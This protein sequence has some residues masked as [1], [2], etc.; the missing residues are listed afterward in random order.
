MAVVYLHHRYSEDLDFFSDRAFSREEL[1]P[2]TQQLQMSLLLDSLEE[3]KVFDRREFFLHN[4]DS[5]RLEFVHYAHPNI[6]S[7]KQWQ[8]IQIDSLDDIAANKIMALVD[9]N[10]PKDA[11][12]MY[13]LLTKGDYSLQKLLGFVKQKFGTEISEDLV[14]S[15]AL[16]SARELDGLKPLLPAEQ[17]QE[18]L[19]A[20]VTSYF[21]N[22]AKDFLKRSLE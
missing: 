15:E 12:D 8:G 19:L 2:F 6:K 9:R 21:E 18:K 3:K 16:K 4:G 20:Q 22:Q 5:V 1:S 14:W 11:F 17:D 13:F 7:H 10:E